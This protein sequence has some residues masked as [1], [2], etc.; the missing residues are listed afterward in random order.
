MVVEH[1]VD[2]SPKQTGSLS[3]D[4]KLKEKITFFN[5]TSARK[6][7]LKKKKRI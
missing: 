1:V 3:L 7:R 4:Q 2:V 5:Y 6:A